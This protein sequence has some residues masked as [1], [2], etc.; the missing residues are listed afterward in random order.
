ATLNSLLQQA[1]AA[2]ADEL[3]LQPEQQSAWSLYQQALA[4]DETNVRAL[5]GQDD[6]RLGLQ[7][8]IDLL[9]EDGDFESAAALVD[10]AEAVGIDSAWAQ[11]VRAA[12]DDAMVD[13]MDRMMSDTMNAIDA[14]EY[15][16]AEANINT[17]IGMGADDGQVSRLRRSL[18]DALRYSGFEPGQLFQDGL[19]DDDA[20]G[21][22]MV[23][24]PLGSF[25]M[26]S[27]DDEDD[28]FENEGPQFRVSFERGFALARNEVSVGEFRRFIEASGYTTD[29]ERRGSSRTYR[30]GSGRIDEM[31][32][33]DW[34]N[35]YLGEAASD[36]LPVVHVS[37][38]DAQ[39]YVDWLARE[40]GRAYRL[41]SEAEFEYALRAGTS[42]RYWWGDE[43]PREP[44]ENVTGDGDE[45][46][47]SRNWTNAFRRY[48]DDF[49]GPAPVGS[50]LPNPFGLHDMGGNV[51]EWL[52]D[53]WHDS[54]VRAPDDGSAWVNPGCTRRMLRGASWSSTPAMSR[55][56]YRLSATSDSTDARV[57]FRV[58]R[59]L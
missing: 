29:A 4:L 32:D 45:F 49:W 8:R 17:L 37:Y 25:I 33:V 58:A 40:T 31:D 10:Q 15:D 7:Q 46:T 51:M 3:L 20:F 12:I 38:N 56:A 42:T 22:V 5:T 21:P 14:G 16:R 24:V 48:T 54:Y 55:S 27:N 28:R 13:E 35:D 59:D 1:D 52:E 6:V 53:C 19:G 36:D 43:S 57:G 39:A 11:P 23:V 18:D 30:E 2:L 50:L 26:G 34:R 47:D 41:P 44:T 9:V